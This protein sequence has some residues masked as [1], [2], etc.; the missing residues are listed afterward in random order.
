[1]D[2]FRELGAGAEKPPF[3][4]AYSPRLGTT[5][6]GFSLEK[7]RVISVATPVLP[8]RKST[9]IADYLTY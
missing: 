2:E 9:C 4:A 8:P 1:M 3:A 7:Q 6:R 5:Q